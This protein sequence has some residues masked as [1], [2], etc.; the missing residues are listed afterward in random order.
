MGL[1]KRELAILGWTVEQVVI[2]TG[3]SAGGM[4]TD[5]ILTP[6]AAYNRSQLFILSA[7]GLTALFG[8]FLSSNDPLQKMLY[9]VASSCVTNAVPL[10]EEPIGFL[11]G[12]SVLLFF[13]CG[14]CGTW[15]LY[16]LSA[17]HSKTV[18][19]ADQFVRGFVPFIIA[20]AVVR[21]MKRFKEKGHQRLMLYVTG[22]YIVLFPEMEGGD[23]KSWTRCLIKFLDS[24]ACNGFVLTL[25]TYG[26][27]ATAASGLQLASVYILVL[28][29]LEMFGIGRALKRA[30][31]C[32]DTFCFNVGQEL[33][34]GLQT[35]A[36]PTAAMWGFTASL[37]VLLYFTGSTAYESMCTVIVGGLSI[38]YANALGDWLQ[39]VACPLER[40]VVYGA[41]FAVLQALTD[42]KSAQAGGAVETDGSGGM[43]DTR[44]EGS[45][46]FNVFKT[47][48]GAHYIP[49]VS[50]FME[51]T[52]PSFEL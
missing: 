24:F 11:V 2:T 41:A 48:T 52:G 33:L 1:S 7:V 49:A 34:N 9:L 39:R 30:D 46:S 10:P 37:C 44:E 51:D 15:A 13:C 5:I 28:L 38:A 6:S 29:A 23:T 20:F 32:K 16:R 3:Y 35:L 8:S 25:T 40:M 22:L 18:P 27:V 21:A 47:S 12:P 14:A 31:F 42:A 45:E 4:I 26:P 43:G 17:V 50:V 36:G 19:Y